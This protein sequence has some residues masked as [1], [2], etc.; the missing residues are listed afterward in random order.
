VKRTY[1]FASGLGC[2]RCEI[3]SGREIQLPVFLGILKHPRAEALPELLRSPAVA[4]KYTMEALRTAAWPILRP[5]PRS[6]LI[7]CL[8][9]APCAPGGG[10]CCAVSSAVS[11][12]RRFA[13]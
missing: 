11:R 3:S 4:R 1:R 13:C 5:F 12:R 7:E 2:V 6:W 10:R 8:K 9:E